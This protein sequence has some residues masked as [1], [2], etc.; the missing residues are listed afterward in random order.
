MSATLLIGWL[1][2]NGLVVLLVVL[3]GN[4][5]V[6]ATIFLGI[7]IALALVGELLHYMNI[8]YRREK[9]YVV[10][11]ALDLAADGAL[12]ALMSAYGMMLYA[13]MYIAFA[14]LFNEVA[15][16]GAREEAK[17]E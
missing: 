6:V 14:V 2:G 16:R 1:I 5:V 11:F 4:G 10:P 8:Q 9:Q 13:F 7:I 12:V 15:K 17:A 3:A